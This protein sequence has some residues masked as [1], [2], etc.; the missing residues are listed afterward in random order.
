MSSV[1]GR[2]LVTNLTPQNFGGGQIS[3]K[4]KLTPTGKAGEMRAEIEIRGAGFQNQMPWA[5]R[6]GRCGEQ[7]QEI[8]N[9]ISYRMLTSAG[10]GTARVN[11]NVQVTIPDGQTHSVVV[12]RS[13]NERSVI[14]SCGVLSIDA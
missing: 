12:Y 9:P 1:P 5:V 13:Q 3:G 2:T 11:T 14:V 6:T 10:D 8:G 4:A 7:G